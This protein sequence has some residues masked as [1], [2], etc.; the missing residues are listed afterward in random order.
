MIIADLPT[1]EKGEEKNKH[2]L[3]APT[4]ITA[5]QNGGEWA[6]NKKEERNDKKA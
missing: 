2:Y 3:K 1:G 6:R 5:Q 4:R